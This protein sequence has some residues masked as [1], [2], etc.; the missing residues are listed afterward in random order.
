MANKLDNHKIIERIKNYMQRNN[1]EEL[2][3]SPGNA[4]WKDICILIHG[5]ATYDN[6]KK[7][8]YLYTKANSPIYNEIQGEKFFNFF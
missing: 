6:Q 7:L 1:L 2:N 3:V 5:N 4:I 8:H